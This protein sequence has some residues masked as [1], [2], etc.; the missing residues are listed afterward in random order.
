LDSIRN[1]LTEEHPGGSAEARKS[2]A[3]IIQAAF[4]HPWPIVQKLDAVTLEAGYAR[5]CGILNATPGSPPPHPQADA[6]TPPPNPASAF[7]AELRRVCANSTNCALAVQWMQRQGWITDEQAASPDPFIHV[8][9]ARM[10]KALGA[11]ER[12]LAAIGA[13]KAVAK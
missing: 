5:L 4:G 9:Q 1:A 3:D 2:R 11:P 6:P 10:E 12:F 7:A 13:G 8:N